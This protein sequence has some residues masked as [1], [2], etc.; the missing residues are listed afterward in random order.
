MSAYFVLNLDTTGPS[1]EI[2]APY[3][4]DLDQ[5]ITIT[6]NADEPIK[7]AYIHE[8]YIIDSL[9]IRY[10]LDY[11]LNTNSIISTLILNSLGVNLGYLTVYAL[12]YDEV[13]N[14]SEVVSK[15]LSTEIPLII[16]IISLEA[17]LEKELS[18]KAYLEK[19]KDL[20]SSIIKSINLQGRIGGE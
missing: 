8:L 14:P 12:I 19:E 7:A 9:G 16:N 17:E 18:L 2:D 10:D 20:D 3:Y 1:A 6:V 11:S 4:V 5:E 13:L 15:K